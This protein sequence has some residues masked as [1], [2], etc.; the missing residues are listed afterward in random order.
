M[1]NV[2]NIQY[3]GTTYGIEGVVDATLSVQGL[4]A[5]AKA[6]GDAIT[7]LEGAS[8]LVSDGDFLPFWRDN[9]GEPTGHTVQITRM[10]T[11]PD[12]FFIPTAGDLI[13]AKGGVV[14][15]V[16]SVTDSQVKYTPIGAIITDHTLSKSNSPADAAAVGTAISSLQ[17][18]ISGAGM[19]N[20]AKSALLNC[21]AKVA[22]IDDDGQSY[23]DALESALGVGNFT[24]TNNLTNVT[25]SNNATSAYG[26]SSYT[27]TLTATTGY[28][29]SVSVTMDGVDVTNS[30]FT[31][32]T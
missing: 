1:P 11:S 26:G 14:Y 24:I 15:R 2:S 30:V 31:P 28:I 3:N 13:I 23:Y 5:D 32:S 21:F 6:V 16:T 22:W 10:R 17:T 29:S 8:D 27:A 18:A 12:S 4:A 20:A 7:E 25:N 19:S 9:D